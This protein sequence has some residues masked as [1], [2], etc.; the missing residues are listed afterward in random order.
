M[1]FKL[2][3]NI[4]NFLTKRSLGKDPQKLFFYSKCKMQA[5]LYEMHDRTPA[6]PHAPT[7]F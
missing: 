7:Q 1:S 2:K 5:W 6:P 3:Y 4:L